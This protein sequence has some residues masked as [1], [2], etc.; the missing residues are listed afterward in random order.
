VGKKNPRCAAVISWAW[1][2][3]ACAL[4]MLGFFLKASST[5]EFSRGD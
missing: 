1:R 2:S 4:R 3:A 5:S